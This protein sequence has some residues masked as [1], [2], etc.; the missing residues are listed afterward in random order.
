[1]TLSKQQGFS[2]IELVIAMLVIS[3]AVLSYEIILYRAK[4]SETLL[5]NDAELVGTADNRFNEFLITG[6]LDNIEDSGSS[7]TITDSGNNNWTFT[8]KNDTDLSINMDLS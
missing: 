8:S 4:S 1:M 7:V 3:I 6:A 2:L 5:T